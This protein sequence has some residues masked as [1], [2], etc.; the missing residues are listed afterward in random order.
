R[1]LGAV[2]LLGLFAPP[3]ESADSSKRKFGAEGVAACTSLISG[4]RREGNAKRRL[5]LI[6]GRALHQ[7]EARN[8]SAAIDDVALARRE[9][10]A[11]GLL[12]DAYFTRSRGRAFDRVESAA[13]ARMGRVEDARAASLRNSADAAF[14]MFTLFAT[15]TYSGLIQKQSGE[16]DRFTAWQTRIAPVLGGLRADRLE[17]DGRF[18]DS[19]RLRD[20]LVEFDAEHTPELNSSLLIARAA[21]AHALAGDFAAA[22]ERAKAARANVEKRKL[23]GKA[24]DNA[25]EVVELLDLYGILE[26]AHSGDSKAARRL[27]A[28]RSQWLSV[29][30]G[31]VM[32]ANRRLRDGAAPDEL[33]GS[34]AK[35]PE[36]L[37]NE[38]VESTRAALLAKDKD[39]RTLFAMVPAE[40]SQKLYAAVAKNVWRTAKSKIILTSKKVDPSKSRMELMYL[41]MTDPVVAMDAYM[42]HAALVARSRG[43]QGFVF[44]PII[45]GSLLGGSFRSGNRGDKGFPPELFIDASEVI[46]DLRRVIPEPVSS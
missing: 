31:S 40:R 1:L 18:S 28:A 3:N 16:E 6:L 17:L 42:L 21:V 33:I 32:E 29:S 14:S 11:A 8:Y 41:P 26:T 7:I 25:A 19:A 22:A 43:H 4:E 34:L 44:M 30:L 20:A 45:G 27:F 10:Q 9:A 2:T 35:T 39:N 12:N 36:D 37:W 13:L 24:E 23:D 38:H 15:S 5:G 46:A